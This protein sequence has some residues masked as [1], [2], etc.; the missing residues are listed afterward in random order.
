MK[1]KKTPFKG[2]VLDFD[3][4]LADTKGLQ[5]EK[6]NI[7]LKPFK[8]EISKEK[9]ISRYCGKSSA[10]EIPELL[11]KEYPQITLS[12]N[13]LAKKVSEILKELFK[14]KAKLMPGALEALK[15]FKQQGFKMAVCS[16]KDPAEL[17]MKLQSVGIA[18][19]FPSENRSTQ[20]EAGGL[21]KPHPAMYELAVKRLGLLPNQC[22]AFED[23][24]A[25]VESAVSA[26]LYVVA[27]PNEWSRGQNFS[28]AHRIIQGGW[29]VFLANPKI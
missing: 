7:A 6:W 9:Y 1:N 16:G 20:S 5:Y 10:T 26:G 22:V 19:W 28:R 23:T 15:W 25:G 17:E 11:K 29:P 4:V 8:I 13:E 24:H 14:K 12:E 27:M 2:V 18:E 3:G 21:P